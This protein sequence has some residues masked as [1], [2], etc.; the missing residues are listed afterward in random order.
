MS[1]M[2]VAYDHCGCRVAAL[3]STAYGSEVASFRAEYAEF[4][5]HVEEHDRIG[6]LRCAKHEHEPIAGVPGPGAVVPPKPWGMARVLPM[7]KRR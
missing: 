2:L 4:E 6:V 5:I 3:L 1:Q 7:R